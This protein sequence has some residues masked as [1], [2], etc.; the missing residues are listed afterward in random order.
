MVRRCRCRWGLGEVVE[1]IS[2]RA[3]NKGWVRCGAKEIVS[4]GV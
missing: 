3:R 1:V 2:R 4:V